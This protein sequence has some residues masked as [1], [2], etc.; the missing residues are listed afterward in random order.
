MFFVMNEIM[1]QVRFNVLVLVVGIID[2]EQD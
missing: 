1:G 2:I